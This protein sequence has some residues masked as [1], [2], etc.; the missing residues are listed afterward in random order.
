MLTPN[1]TTT[2]DIYWPCYNGTPGYDIECDRLD[3]VN[4]TLLDHWTK[5][6]R[7]I[8]YCVKQNRTKNHCRLNYSPIIMIGIALQPY[9][10]DTRA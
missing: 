10:K 1:F 4:E 6:G 8:L 3:K 9:F 2:G 5:F 7:K